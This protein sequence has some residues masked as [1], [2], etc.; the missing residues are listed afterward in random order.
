MRKDKFLSSGKCTEARLIMVRDEEWVKSQRSTG[1]TD[2]Y[3]ETP[4]R[5][6]VHRPDSDEEAARVSGASQ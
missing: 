4:L 5:L 3:S 6:T 1:R 2:L